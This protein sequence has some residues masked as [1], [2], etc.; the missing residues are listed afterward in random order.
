MHSYCAW[1]RNNN[2]D[3]ICFRIR[4]AWLYGNAYLYRLLGGNN[5]NSI[6]NK[7]IEEYCFKSLFD[8]AR[9]YCLKQAL[10]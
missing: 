2:A 3:I 6:L 4:E 9:R 1:C 8:R 7:E 5:Y 10:R